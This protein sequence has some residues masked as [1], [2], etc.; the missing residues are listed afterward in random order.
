MLEASLS[1]VK[2]DLDY[3]NGAISDLQYVMNNWMFEGVVKGAEFKRI[4]QGSK[5][6]EQP[7]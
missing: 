7:G 4:F 5:T 6:D 2:S 1:K 3:T